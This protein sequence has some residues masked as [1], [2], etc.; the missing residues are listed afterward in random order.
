MNFKLLLTVIALSY[1]IHIS[2]QEKDTSYWQH[3]E[4]FGL[5]F[6]QASFSKNWKGGA[7]NSISMGALFLGKLNYQK[8]KISW[9]NELDLQYGVLKNQDQNARK[10]NDRIFFDSKL[11][12]KIAD[13]WNAFS[14]LN[15]QTQF[16]K[17]YDYGVDENRA[18]TRT[19][20]SAFMSPAFITSSWGAE[21]KPNDYFSLRLS[22]FSP[23]ITMVNDTSIY[24]NVPENYGVE[25]GETVRYEWFAFKL[26][27]SFEKDLVENINF[28]ARYE[29]F[30]N[31]QEFEARKFDHRLDAGLTAKIFKIVNLSLMSIV[32]YDFDQINE[33]Q[34]SFST[35]LSLLFILGSE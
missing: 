5:N 8:A 35:A 20:I 21:Y 30:T 18:E 33:V 12:Y 7:N 14:S 2:A 4:K 27:A 10:S 13:K 22:P 9:N 31:Y 26:S 19:L 29:L 1:A 15:F 11:G 3:S 16:D 23:R 32:L 6:N 24:N 28:K 17:G 25:I 34:A